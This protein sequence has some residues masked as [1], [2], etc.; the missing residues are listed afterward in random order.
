MFR[1]AIAAALALGTGAA[2]ADSGAEAHKGH[3][4][5][6]ISLDA[7]GHIVAMTAH[8]RLI[9]GVH[10]QIDPLVRRWAFIPGAIDGKSVATETNLS[11]DF[12][13]V[14]VGEDR[15]AVRIDSARTGAAIV[16]KSDKPPKYP[17]GEISKGKSGLAVLDISYDAD[18]NVLEVE[19]AK[20]APPVSDDFY[21]A[22]TATARTWKLTPEVV[23]GR[24]IAGHIV[25]PMC[26]FTV[27]TLGLPKTMPPAPPACDWIPPGER[28]ALHDGDALALAPAARLRDDVTTHA[29]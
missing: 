23:G 11:V 16:E 15:Y 27:R 10:E 1:F 17:R 12:T 26:F 6:S 29:P 8:D 19:H 24:A 9:D 3:G 25:S 2:I 5:W 18:G 22:A 20:G 13:L 4:S 28:V 14:P 21:R 7:G